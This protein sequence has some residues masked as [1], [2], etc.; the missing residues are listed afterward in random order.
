M[1]QTQGFTIPINVA[2]DVR[3]KLLKSGNIERGWLGIIMQPLNRSYAKYLKQPEMEG[4]L[5]PDVIENS[6][7]DKAGVKPGDVILEYGD[8]KLSAE[9]DDDLNKLTLLIAQTPVGTEKELSIYRDGQSRKLKVKIGEQP[10]VK[11]DEFETQFGFTVKEITD[12]MFRTYLL[13]TRDGVYVSFVDVG[14][15][16]DKGDL[17]EGDV[18][19]AVN[20]QP[21][22]DFKSFKETMGR[23]A[24]DD[25]ILLSALR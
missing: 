8:Q 2:I 23:V 4:I 3:D 13:Q 7:A 20:N 17:G 19:T 18:I 11:A 12:D 15:V 9:K 6:P 10:K 14:T 1:G 21:T 5:V 24:N 16:A 22:P 25:F